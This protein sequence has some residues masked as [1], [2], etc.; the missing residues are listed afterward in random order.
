MDHIEINIY[1]K[2]FNKKKI[3]EQ[4]YNE[5]PDLYDIIKDKKINEIDI[6]LKN[7]YNINIKI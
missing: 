1:A 5:N 7:N 2:D 6:I 3:L 4:L